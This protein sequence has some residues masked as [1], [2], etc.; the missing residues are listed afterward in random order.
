[1]LK[2]DVKNKYA[3]T[4]HEMHRLEIR[5]FLAIRDSGG[6]NSVLVGTAGAKGFTM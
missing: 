2:H 6:L 5:I 1:M 3:Q 4:S